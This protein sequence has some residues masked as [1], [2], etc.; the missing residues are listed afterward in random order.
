VVRF[1]LTIYPYSLDEDDNVPKDEEAF[2]KIEDE[3]IRARCNFRKICGNSN[4]D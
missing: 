1:A 3:R 4:F 2:V